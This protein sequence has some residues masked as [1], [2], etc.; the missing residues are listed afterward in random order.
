M[1]VSVVIPTRWDMHVLQWILHALTQQTFKDFD[2]YLVVDAHF[3]HDADFFVWEQNIHDH[4]PALHIHVFSHV[5][6]P[7]GRKSHNASFL[8]NFGI[9]HAQWAYIHMFD[10]DVVFA[11]DFLQK[12]LEYYQ[13]FSQTISKD[14][15]ITPTMMYRKTDV[16]QSQWFSSFSFLL[17]RPI[18]CVLGDASYAKISMYSWNSLF[19]T[20]KIFTQTLF[21]ETLDFV[22]EDL[23]F[24]YRISKTYTILV[25]K[26]LVIFHMERDKTVLENLWI[27]SPFQTYRRVKH[28]ILFVKKNGNRYQKAMAYTVWLL[29]NTWWLLLRI[30][31]H[32]KT[33]ELS[34]LTKALWQGFRDGIVS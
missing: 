9:T 32:G 10:D 11:P 15:V 26:D 24:T 25:F 30:L 22:N 16:V 27:W 17:C 8:R 33:T 34:K 28:R 2:V 6:H 21:D 13:K 20:S 18:A 23:D 3:T 29:G 4:Y 14:I 7:K 12:T 1:L 5:S 19:G 31:R